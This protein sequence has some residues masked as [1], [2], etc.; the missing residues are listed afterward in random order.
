MAFLEPCV[1]SRQRRRYRS[2]WPVQCLCRARWPGAPV[3]T[4]R[5]AAKE[6]PSVK[7]R[8][9][10]GCPARPGVVSSVLRRSQSNGRGRSGGRRLERVAAE[11]GCFRSSPASCCRRFSSEI[12]SKGYHFGQCLTKGRTFVTP[13]MSVTSSTKRMISATVNTTPTGLCPAGI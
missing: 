12:A 4:F 9:L 8:R 11:Q 7:A 13:R 5:L 6:G 1:S 2:F 3:P 10:G